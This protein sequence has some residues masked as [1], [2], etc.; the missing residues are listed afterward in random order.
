MSDAICTISKVVKNYGPF[1]ALHGIDLTVMPGEFIALVGPSGSGKST[2][3]QIISGFEHPTEGTLEIDG[4][5]M[6]GISLSA[7]RRKIARG[8]S[9]P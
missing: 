1:R 9:G 6:T 8:Q 3:L 4:V 2:L 5:D 7:C